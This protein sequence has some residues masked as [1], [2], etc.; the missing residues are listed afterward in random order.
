M[1]MKI[2][3]LI[4]L[5]RYLADSKLTGYEL[6]VARRGRTGGL[7]S[8]RPALGPYSG[9]SGERRRKQ[10]R[11]VQQ[12]QPSPGRHVSEATPEAKPSPI[13]WAVSG[14]PEVQSSQTATPPPPIYRKER[15]QEV[16]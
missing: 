14:R 15:S 9:R 3:G 7:G 2:D 5:S 13:D 6:R 8:E 16:L 4:C 12:G 10:R 11:A 1:F